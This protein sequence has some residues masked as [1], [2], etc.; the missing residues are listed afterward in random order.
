MQIDSR[1]CCMY[2][3]SVKWWVASPEL[4][5][6]GL[7]KHEHRQH[8]RCWQN[9]LEP[10]FILEWFALGFCSSSSSLPWALVVVV[11]C[12]GS[13]ES[14]TCASSWRPSIFSSLSVLTWQPWPPGFLSWFFTESD[15]KSISTNFSNRSFGS[16]C[17]CCFTTWSLKKSSDSSPWQ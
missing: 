14:G 1:L 3:T 8:F 10:V 11:S 13:P 15:H 7:K 17:C 4:R 2:K 9:L 16:S 5:G 12:S 6:H